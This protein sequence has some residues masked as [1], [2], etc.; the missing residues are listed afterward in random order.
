MKA[1]KQLSIIECAKDG[2][3]NQHKLCASKEIEGF[4]SWEINN[5]I[6]SGVRDLKDLAKLTDYVGDLNF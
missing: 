4:P 2:K 1:V 3:D 6:Y 5:E